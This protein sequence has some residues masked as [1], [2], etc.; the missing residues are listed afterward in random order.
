MKRFILA[1]LFALPSAL[2]SIAMA[3]P[4]GSCHFHGKKTAAQA[5]IVQCAEQRKST[6]IKAGRL[7]KSWADIAPSTVDMVDGKKGKEWRVIYQNPA[8][9]DSAKSS[10]Y[11]FF[12][13]PGNFIAANHTGN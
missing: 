13:P 11:L 2:P 4:G 1:V 8:A 12:T 6:L 5:T 3:D 10:L 9:S 7:E